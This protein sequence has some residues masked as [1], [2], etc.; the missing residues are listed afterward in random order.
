VAHG[1]KYRYAPHASSRLGASYYSA[2]ALPVAGFF[3]RTE[4]RG[5]WQR[6]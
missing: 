2:G 3:Q 5:C 1:K 6:H 4:H